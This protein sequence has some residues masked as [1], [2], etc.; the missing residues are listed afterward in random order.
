MDQSKTHRQRVLHRIE[1]EWEFCCLQFASRRS[2]RVRLY[3]RTQ[4]D[5]SL[6]PLRCLFG[7]MTTLIRSHRS[8]ALKSNHS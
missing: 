8:A 1:G 5:V 4:G 3:E 2:S 6:G 7:I